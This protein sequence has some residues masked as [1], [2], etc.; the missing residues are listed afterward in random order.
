MAD[1]GTF[2]FAG[3]RPEPGYHEVGA[4]YTSQRPELVDDFS[5]PLSF[6]LEPDEPTPTPTPTP[7]AEAPRPT[8]MPTVDPPLV[9]PASSK[10]LLANRRLH[11][12]RRGRVRLRLLCPAAAVR[13][14]VERVRISRGGRTLA[15]RSVTLPP[16]RVRTV[17]LRL[18]AAARR[19][20]TGRRRALAVL[21]RIG[22]AR[23]IRA[24]LSRRAAR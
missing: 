8:P 1:D 5:A 9:A 15:T 3:W 6:E 20:L 17:A 11:A 24:T 14:C 2:A 19:S 18:G 21:V 22:E 13:P 23:A 16:G 7:P 10:V 4:R 12:D